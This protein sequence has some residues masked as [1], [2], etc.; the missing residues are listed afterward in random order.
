MGRRA[1][2]SNRRSST[3]LALPFKELQSK[4]GLFS[5]QWCDGTI[6]DEAATVLRQAADI[7]ID[8]SQDPTQTCNGISIGL[9]FTAARAQI[10]SVAPPMVPAPDPCTAQ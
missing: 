5:T 3:S 8:G 7:M 1:R 9:N 4:A 6:F 2:A 10:S